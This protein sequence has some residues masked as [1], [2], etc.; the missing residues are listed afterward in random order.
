MLRTTVLAAL[1]AAL[2]VPAPALAQEA[3]PAPTATPPQG[4][5][6]CPFFT[7]NASS[8]V[9]T[10]QVATITATLRD[11]EAPARFALLRV[12]PAPTAVV[13]QSDTATSTVSWDVRLGESH[14]FEVTA[15]RGESCIGGTG[16]VRI[17]ASVRPSLSISA[18]RNAARDYTFAG[19]VLPARGQLVTLYRHDAGRR[20]VTAQSRV[21]SNGLYRF[22][23]RFTGS[24][25]FGF[26][27]GV[28]QS[29][30][31]LA[32]SSPIRPTVIH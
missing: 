24:G 13:R 26:S 16:G 28:G 25:R 10:G 19:R 1:A 23:R 5:K 15:S 4:D 11:G 31:N 17:T 20:I 9:D 7:V 6:A 2:L 18:T 22:D 27:A 12:A 30:T 29:S 14:T 21:G 32:G 3:T 8:I